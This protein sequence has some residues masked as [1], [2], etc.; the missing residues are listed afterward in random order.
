MSQTVTLFDSDEHSSV[1][2]ETHRVSLRQVRA[3][4]LP[5]EGTRYSTVRRELA[6][7]CNNTDVAENRRW[8]SDRRKCDHDWVICF[9]MTAG[10]KIEP[11]NSIFG[12]LPKNVDNKKLY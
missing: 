7:S 6:K 5:V 11:M 9:L 8:G 1:V 3:L 4:L 2:F 10:R 12:R